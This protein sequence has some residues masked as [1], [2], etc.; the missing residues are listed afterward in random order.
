VS[1]HRYKLIISK[2]TPRC[3][4]I[5]A[6]FFYYKNYIIITFYRGVGDKKDHIYL[7]LYHLP[8]EILTERLPGISHLAWVFGGVDIF[9]DPIPVI[10][11]V[12]YNMG[13]I[14]TNWRAQVRNT[15]KYVHIYIII[16]SIIAD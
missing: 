1:F 5:E 16:N 13:G 7:Q 4:K 11:T 10:P 12:H 15:T 8:Q 2:I 9:K 6:T 14:P 3:A